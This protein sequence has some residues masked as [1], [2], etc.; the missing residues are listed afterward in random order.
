MTVRSLR[1]G[2]TLRYKE[3]YYTEQNG[4]VKASDRRVAATQ[5]LTGVV[6]ETAIPIEV[7]ATRAGSN[8]KLLVSLRPDK[9]AL[10]NKSGRWRG[11]ISFVARF[12]KEDGSEAGSGSS[13]R[14]EFNLTQ[15]SYEK[16]QRDGLVF[17]KTLAL[18]KGAVRL[19]VLVQNDPSSEVGTLTIPLAEV[20][21]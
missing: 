19:R 2:V 14:V 15:Q 20:P 5:A 6:D 3:G 11:A 17:S 10:E 7:T 13:R 16:G 8:L 1:P 12:A 9:L 21:N 4:K 18:P